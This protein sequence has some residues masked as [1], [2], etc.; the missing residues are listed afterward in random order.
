[1]THDN[2]HAD[3]IALREFAETLQRLAD[4]VEDIE[5]NLGQRLSSLGE[6]FRDEDYQRFREHFRQR[7][8]YLKSF[9]EQIRQHCP[10]ILRDSETLLSMQQIKLPE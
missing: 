2:A 8:Q 1:M 3:P 6:T 9:V 4:S 5:S 7:Q 10:K